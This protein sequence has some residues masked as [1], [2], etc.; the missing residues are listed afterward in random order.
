M[1]RDKMSNIYRGSCIDASY[2][3]SAYLA[4]GFQSKKLKCDGRLTTDAKEWQ[5]LTLPLAK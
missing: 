3:V 1:D 4:E 2:Q 5:K